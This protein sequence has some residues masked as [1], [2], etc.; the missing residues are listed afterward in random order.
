MRF[1]LGLIFVVGIAFVSYIGGSLYPAPPEL[2]ARL[3]AQSVA[4]HI[5]RELQ[6]ADVSA[7][8]SSLGEQRFNDLASRASQLAAAAGSAVMVEHQSDQDVIG[9]EAP[10]A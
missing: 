5:Q 6:V 8:R 9:A 4:D 7:L 10:L 3:D 1:V 2:L